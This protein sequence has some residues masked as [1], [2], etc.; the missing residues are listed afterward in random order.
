VTNLAD[1]GTRIKRFLAGQAITGRTDVELDMDGNVSL[2]LATINA[3][4]NR[5]QYGAKWEPP[6]RY[7]A[8]PFGQEIIP[9]KGPTSQKGQR[10]YK[11]K[12][13]REEKVA[14]RAWPRGFR[15]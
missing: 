7:V 10:E 8:G 14:R 5:E 2:Q 11:R 6:V 13:S 15:G 9:E 3:A 4:R 1:A 12:F